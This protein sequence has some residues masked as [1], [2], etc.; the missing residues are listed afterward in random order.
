[1]SVPKFRSSSVSKG[2]SPDVL[3][4]H[5]TWGDTVLDV[6]ELSP[7][8]AFYIGDPAVSSLPVDLVVPGLDDARVAL[9]TVDGPDVLLHVPNGAES[10][11]LQ[12][13]TPLSQGEFFR[14]SIGMLTLTVGLGEREERCPRT[15]F[16]TDKRVAF[17][18]AASLAA[19]AA[20]AASL[21]LFT[22]PLGLTDD[23]DAD[24]DKQYLMMAFLDAAAERNEKEPPP[25]DGPG[26]GGEGA[27]LPP[28]GAKG[29]SGRMGKRDATAQ[30]R[31]ASGT[32]SGST[33]RAATS[34]A[35]ELAMAQNFGLIGVLNSGAAAPTHAPWE[36]AGVGE[37]AFAG[38]FFGEIGEQSGVGG[39]GLSGIGEGGGFHGDRIG[40]GG[41]GTC[42]ENGRK[43]GLGGNGNGLFGSSAGRPGGTHVAS[44]PRVR[45][46]GIT[47]VSGHLPASTIQ[48][49]VQQN[50]GRFRSCYE[51]G[52]KSNPNLT[53]RVTARFVISR[54][55]SVANV[56]SGGSDLPDPGVVSCVLRAYGTLSFPAPM[57]GIVKVSY[58]IMF[59]P[60]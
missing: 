2:S 59:S 49:V 31:R 15:S 22:P 20:F 24:R 40:L 47:E 53:G 44:V 10:S 56:A 27:P 52:L 33:P 57:D 41:I 32:E 11:A 54:D 5:V 39:L 55:G 7:P 60:A 50:F 45:P 43:C 36:D 48:R 17:F 25:S 42:G 30:E 1:M 18:F 34:R 23:E 37:A 4:I 28:D 3:E 13:T 38:G 12:S 14:V 26:G 16:A 35:E 6:I 21:A 8:R 46:A 9:V 29:E 58:P 19:H 51:G